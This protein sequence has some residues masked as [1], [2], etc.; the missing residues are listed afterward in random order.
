MGETMKKGRTWVTGK[1]ETLRKEK[2]EEEA[3]KVAEGRTPQPTETASTSQDASP[4]KAD[5]AE[6]N[7]SEVDEP[8]LSIE[9]TPAKR[10]REE[11]EEEQAEV[12]RAV[13][14]R[15][16]EIERNGVW[17][18]RDIREVVGFAPSSTNITTAASTSATVQSPP[19]SA[20]VET[21]ATT[22]SETTAPSSIAGTTLTSTSTTPTATPRDL[23]GKRSESHPDAMD[24]DEPLQSLTGGLK[25]GIQGVDDVISPISAELGAKTEGLEIAEREGDGGG[26]MEVEVAGVKA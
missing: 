8:V 3:R 10:A 18:G 21:P 25:P 19:G 5:D 26:G 17:K 24:V 4:T 22:I 11:D 9:G 15:R 13:R 6:D 12:E 14:E 1:I 7:D 23:T 16:R 2:E 20:S